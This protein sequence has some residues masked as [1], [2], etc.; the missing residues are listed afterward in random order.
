MQ[1][2]IS[3]ITDA[4]SFTIEDKGGKPITV[5][6]YPDA[7][8]HFRVSSNVSNMMELEDNLVKVFYGFKN[9][10]GSFLI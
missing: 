3:V 6:A 8:S 4:D 2:P 1:I 9:V 10:H 7:N 5:P